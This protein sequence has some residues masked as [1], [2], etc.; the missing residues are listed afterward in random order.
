MMKNVW[1]SVF[2]FL[3]VHEKHLPNNIH[4]VEDLAHEELQEVECVTASV[5]SEV[6]DNGADPLRSGS[7]VN[8]HTRLK[9]SLKVLFDYIL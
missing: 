4:K 8:N 3:L 1:N 9:H 5:V 2:K 7:P 6:F